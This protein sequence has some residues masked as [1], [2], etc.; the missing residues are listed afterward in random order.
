L[1]SHPAKPVDRQ[2]G[3]HSNR[4][5]HPPR[6]YLISDFINPDG[7]VPGN[8]LTTQRPRLSYRD[9]NITLGDTYVFS[10]NTINSVHLAVM[11]NRT[12]RAPAPGGGVGADYGIKQF[13]PVPNLFILNVTNGF[14]VGSTVGALAI[15]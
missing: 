1:Q 15:F 9:Q 5:S 8:G 14:S 13:N 4:N 6:R 11:R 10:P 2:S 3:V 12:T 7:A